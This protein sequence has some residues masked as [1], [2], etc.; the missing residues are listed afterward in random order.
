MKRRLA[1]IALIGALVVALATATK[2]QLL[3]FGVGA[4]SFSTGAGAAGCSAGQLD[5]SDSCN[6]VFAGH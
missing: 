6:L 4:G 5:F 3:L 2:A 1:V